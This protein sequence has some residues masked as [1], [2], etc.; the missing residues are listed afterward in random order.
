MES[1][2][3]IE[4]LISRPA[5]GDGNFPLSLG[6]LKRF[7]NV[8]WDIPFYH[9]GS[10]CKVMPI[11]LS[12]LSDLNP[13]RMVLK[14]KFPGTNPYFHHCSYVQYYIAVRSGK[15][16]GRVA[17]FIDRTYHERGVA[18]TIGWIG[19]LECIDD[20]DI[21]DALLDAAIR[22]LRAA[23]AVKIIGPAKFNA[24]G[25]NGVLIDGF[26]KHPMVMEPYHPPYYGRLLARHGV[27]E[28]D[29]YAFHMDHSGA[30]SYMDRIQ[31]MH[32]HGMGLESR[33]K[34]EGIRIRTANLADWENEIARVKEIYNTAWDTSDHPQ[35]SPFSD[36]EFNYITASVRMIAIAGLLFI[37]ED[38]TRPG[39]PAIGMS[40]TLPDLNELIEEYDDI[41]GAYRPSRH[42][43]GLAD[44]RRD[45]GI[46]RLLRS[47]IKSGKF[48]NA[49]VFILGTLRKKT[50]LDALLYLK[51]YFATRDMGIKVASGSQIADT[52]LE[53]VNPLVRMGTPEITWRV[54]RFDGGSQEP[55][56]MASEA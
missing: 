41:H 24:N 37:V 26:D 13:D 7:I 25:E 51:T 54:F 1:T 44:I 10:S 52:N 20:D 3:T 33:M 8:L 56:D 17:A 43:Y 55:I 23:G 48:T 36:E 45:L 31:H 30:S 38:T 11:L 42:V 12:E 9:S 46:Y 5:S 22:D 53:M 2:I 15:S 21:A 19:L 34:R 18:G 47:R 29:W 40:V 35:F 27:K 28:N 49:R 16:A 32:Q 50:G 39:N 14:R 4:R 6:Q